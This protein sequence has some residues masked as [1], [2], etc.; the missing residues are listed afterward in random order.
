VKRPAATAGVASYTSPRG[1]AACYLR[2]RRG[3]LCG[4]GVARR[5]ARRP[6]ARRSADRPAARCTARR[7]CARP[8]RTGRQPGARPGVPAL[9]RPAAASVRQARGS[10]RTDQLSLNPLAESRIPLVTDTGTRQGPLSCLPSR[11]Q[12]AFRAVLP[13]CSGGVTAAIHPSRLRERERAL[14]ISTG[15]GGLGRV[16]RPRYWLRPR[17]RDVRRARPAGS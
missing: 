8:T 13:H 17:P 9:G 11:F 7:L 4:A 12:G 16:T 1:G 15:R 3:L 6:A 14:T 2:T 10:T 5:S